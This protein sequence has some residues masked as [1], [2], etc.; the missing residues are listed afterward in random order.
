MK[1]LPTWQNRQGF[2]KFKRKIF[3]FNA[4]TKELAE[5][6]EIIKKDIVKETVQPFQPYSTGVWNQCYQ[7]LSKLLT[8]TS[9]REPLSKLFKQPP[10]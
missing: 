3:V 10:L 4:Y 6:Q 2:K 5:I 8:F 7:I 1:S 9:M